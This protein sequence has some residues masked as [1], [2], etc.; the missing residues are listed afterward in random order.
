MSVVY[1]DPEPSGLAEIV[2]ELIRQN[3]ERDPGRRGHLTPLVASIAVPDADVGVT[4]RIGQR[5]VRV[6][7]GIAADAHLRMRARS[8][9]LVRL[10]TAPLLLGFPDPFRAEGRR[11][12]ADLLAGRVRVVGLLRHPV[13]TARLSALLSVADG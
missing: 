8:D 13:R 7:N 4:I 11:A 9:A 6:V 2:G 3:L 5:D 12:I 10:T 1:G